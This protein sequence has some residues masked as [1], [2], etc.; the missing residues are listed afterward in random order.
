MEIVRNF[1]NIIGVSP[2]DE[3]P[4]KINGQIVQHSEIETI[5]I[6]DNKPEAKSIYE[7]MVDVKV[8]SIRTINAPLGKT[9]LV[10]G[11]KQYKIIYTENGDCEKANI[12]YINIPY[13]TFF[14]VSK[15][16]VDIGI[17]N[18]KV[19]ILD[20]YFDLIS[21]RTIYCH[22]VYLLDAKYSC[23]NINIELNEEFD[24]N[25]EILSEISICKDKYSKDK[26]NK[27]IDIDAEYL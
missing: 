19:Y 14:E 16:K 5:I 6:P 12:L 13:N 10:D 26:I 3:L 27:L 7:I 23:E 9:I 21:S 1:I 25:K 24:Y 20:A 11:E 15:D 4:N 22:S 8:K 17:N 2:E 18:I